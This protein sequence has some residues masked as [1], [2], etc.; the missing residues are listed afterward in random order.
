MVEYRTYIVANG[1]VYFFVFRSEKENF[2]NL[3]GE[4]DAILQSF[5]LKKT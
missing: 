3:R 2:E 1:K 5:E 4:F